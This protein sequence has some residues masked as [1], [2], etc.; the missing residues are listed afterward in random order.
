M[1]WTAGAGYQDENFIKTGWKP[2]QPLDETTTA[3][4][5]EKNTCPAKIEEPSRPAPNP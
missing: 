2:Q 1:N 4:G 5:E 3:G